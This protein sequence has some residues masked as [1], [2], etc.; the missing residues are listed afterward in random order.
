MLSQNR[1]AN[2]WRSDLLVIRENIRWM[3]KIGALQLGFGASLQVTTG[4]QMMMSTRPDLDK[5][6][7]LIHLSHLLCGLCVIVCGFLIRGVRMWS[8]CGFTYACLLANCACLAVL[9]P[10]LGFSHLTGALA[11][12]M[13]QRQLSIAALGYNITN[14]E[15]RSQSYMTF[16][17]SYLLM[18]FLSNVQVAFCIMLSSFQ[19]H[20]CC[21]TVSFR[22]QKLCYAGMFVKFGLGLF[23]WMNR[24]TN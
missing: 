22:E 7:P 9:L 15:R 11:V 14:S 2:Q 4:L 1:R 6:R 10:P 21:M 13:S 8:T 19:A 12:H 5:L 24:F 18:Y 23:R 16:I 3:E 17:N 20:L